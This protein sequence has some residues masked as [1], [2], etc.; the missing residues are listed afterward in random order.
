[1]AVTAGLGLTAMLLVGVG[2]VGA[3]PGDLD[4]TFSSDGKVTTDIGTTDAGRAVAI[5]SDGKIVV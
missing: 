1:M 4:T 2:S 3:A 5:Q